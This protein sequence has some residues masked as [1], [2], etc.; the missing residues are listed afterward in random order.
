MLHGRADTAVPAAVFAATAADIT[1][2]VIDGRVIVRDGQH[3]A[4][5]VADELS[6][7]IS[8]VMDR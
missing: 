3:H 1:D 8:E 4:I 6:R 2:V 5:D 7:S